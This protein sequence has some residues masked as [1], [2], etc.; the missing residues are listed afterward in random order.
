VHWYVLKTPVTVSADQI[1][2]FAHLYPS[3]ARSAQP[4]HGRVVLSSK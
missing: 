4:L 2:T 3:N 1:A